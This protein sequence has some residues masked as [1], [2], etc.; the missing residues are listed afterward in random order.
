MPMIVRAGVPSD[1][2][3]I[4]AVH[5]ESWR[6]T[7]K[8]H[9]PDDILAGLSVEQRAEI[10]RGVMA[11]PDP[12]AACWCWRTTGEVVGFCHYCPERDSDDARHRRDHVDLSA[13]RPLAAGRWRATH[14]RGGRGN[15]GRGVHSSRAVGPR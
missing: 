4:A 12:G 2:D 9:V 6:S 15:D 11:R 10:W 14:G 1:V 7:Y 13:G 8:G 3:G 5:V